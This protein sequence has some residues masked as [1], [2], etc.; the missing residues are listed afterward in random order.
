MVDESNRN[1]VGSVRSKLHVRLAD[2]L[3]DLEFLRPVSLE[4]HAEAR[5]RDIPYSHKKRDDLFAQALNK[6]NRFALL[7]AEY[8]EQ[9]VGFLFCA[10]G[11]YIVGY[12]DLITTVYSF[13]VR[14]Q[15]RS[16]LIGGKAALR[17]LNGVVKWS[18]PR[19]V[20]EIMIHVTSGIDIQRTDKFL[21]RTGFGVVGANYALRLANDKEE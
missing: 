10:V 16:T 11:E 17:L 3:Q 5:F 8:G 13:Y 18:K 1:V 15:Y 7:I 9:P 12:Q 14:K 21:R 4:F 19:R 20:R 2:S 6:P